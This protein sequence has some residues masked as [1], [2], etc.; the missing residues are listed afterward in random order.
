M[1]EVGLCLVIITRLLCV[2]LLDPL[3]FPLNV[4]TYVMQPPIATSGETASSLK[5]FPKGPVVRDCWFV[6]RFEP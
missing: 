1:R 3:V 6:F 2:V 4:D 5:V